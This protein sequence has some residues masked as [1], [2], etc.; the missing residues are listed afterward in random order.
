MFSN[1]LS[2]A[3]FSGTFD[4][5]PM[6]HDKEADINAQDGHGR[7]AVHLA[8]WH[9]VLQNFHW[10]QDHNGDL[11]VKDYQGRTV[12][13]HAAMGGNLAMADAV[14]EVGDAQCR[15]YR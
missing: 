8:A 1:A 15:G 6:L 10:L 9:G 3:V 2:A 5:V 14:R 4:I 11:E 12:A 13:H 7:T